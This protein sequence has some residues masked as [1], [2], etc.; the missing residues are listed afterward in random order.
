MR[1]LTDIDSDLII[2]HE[3]P[4]MINKLKSSDFERGTKNPFG[5]VEPLLC[6]ATT[7]YATKLSHLYLLSE[8]RRL[9]DTHFLPSPYHFWLLGHRATRNQHQ[10][11][12]AAVCDTPQQLLDLCQCSKIK[13][14]VARKSDLSHCAICL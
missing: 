8:S 9:V 1:T 7:R 10:A 5:Q 11:L 12:S 3:S 6:W 2:K 13:S 4:V 14:I